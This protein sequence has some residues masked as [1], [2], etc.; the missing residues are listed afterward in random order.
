MAAKPKPP[1]GVQIKNGRFYRVQYVGMVNG[2]RRYK[3]HPLTRISDGLPALYK[4]LAEMSQPVRATMPARLDQWLAHVL[5]SLGALEQKEM[6]RKVQVV[7]KAF[8]EFEIEHV[9]AR[10]V[11]QF[12][13]H[14]TAQGKLRMAKSYRAMLHAFFKWAIVQG[15]RS[16]N[17]VEPV[18]T[19]PPKP[20]SRYMTDA[21]FV[22]IRSHLSPIMQA[23]VD[24]LYLTGQRAKDIRGLRWSQV[25]AEVIHFQPSKTIHSTAV[26]VDIPITEQIAEVLER[27]KGL[28]L[29][30]ARLTPYVIHQAN[31]APYS[32]HGMNSAW[33]KARA[34]TSIKDC[35]LR[36]I[37]AKHATDAEKAGH[38]VEEISQGLAHADASM[39]RTYLKT[40]V[41]KRGVVSL[42]IPK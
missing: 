20:R 24:L 4:T 38:S 26:K 22:E 31:G 32:Q 18:S 33:D 28:M 5:P 37:R 39:T 29:G 2:K 23:F 7:G 11:L 8:V 9:E 19:R 35:T 17:P 13:N 15:A 6:S 1:T 25:D 3:W 14:W 42:K 30:A 34:K 21:E 41:A 16:D 12:L 27:A 40:R 36:D 10:H